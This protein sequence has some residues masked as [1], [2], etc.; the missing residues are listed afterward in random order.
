VSTADAIRPP[1]KATAAPPADKKYVEVVTYFG[2]NRAPRQ[3]VQ[4]AFWIHFRRFFA[5]LDGWTLI[6]VVLVALAAGWGL[7]CLLRRLPAAAAD[8]AALAAALPRWLVLVIVLSVLLSACATLVLVYA[9]WRT[10]LVLAV[11]LLFFLA[12]AWATYGG[13]GWLKTGVSALVALGLIAVGA[14]WDA[15]TRA[16]IEG[17][18]RGAHFTADSA[19]ELHVGTCTVTVPRS[20]IPSHLERPQPVVGVLVDL[21]DP[22][23]DLTVKDVVILGESAFLEPL[24]KKISEGDNGSAFVFVHGFNTTFEE[25][26]MRTA[27]MA[28]DLQFKGAPVFFSWPSQGTVA[29]YFWDAD[30]VGEC[31]PY[32]KTFLTLI[33]RKSG[34]K[35][36]YVLAHSMGNRALSQALVDLNGEWKDASVNALFREIVLA[37]PD[38]NVYTFAS[39]YAPQLLKGYPH[40]TLYANSNDRALALSRRL[41]HS[42]RLGESGDGIFVVKKLDSIDVSALDTNFDGHGYYGDNHIVLTDLHTLWDQGMPLPRYPIGQALFRNGLP[43][44]VFPPLGK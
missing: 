37:A 18:Q 19:H 8:P 26:A 36:I 7:T 11:L 20:H 33:A 21:P 40:L 16:A 32:L 23:R 9:G 38:V 17:L 3:G 43:Y 42:P 2:T 10:L 27:Q 25:A 35:R 22:D 6:G 15:H 34:A 24:K 30:A 5:T 1:V 13:G 44:Y 4:G 28:T 41:N 39:A 14:A 29:G 12:V 31:V